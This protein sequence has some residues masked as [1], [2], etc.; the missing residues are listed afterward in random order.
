MKEFFM[1]LLIFVPRSSSI[2]LQ[3]KCLESIRWCIRSFFANKNIDTIF[4]FKSAW[5]FTIHRNDAT[6]VDITNKKSECQFFSDKTIYTILYVKSICL[7][8]IRRSDAAHLTLP[9][10]N[11][12]LLTKQIFTWLTHTIISE[13]QKSHSQLATWTQNIDFRC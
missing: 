7:F 1:W 9:T 6:F 5:L 10:T 2:T 3:N 4:Q 11:I 8:T 12:D 13:Q